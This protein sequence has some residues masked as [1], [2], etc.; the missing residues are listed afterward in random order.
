MGHVKTVP[1]VKRMYSKII[2]DKFS[3]DKRICGRRHERDP[4]IIVLEC[5]FD[6]NRE[7]LEQIKEDIEYEKGREVEWG[8]VP[9]GE[10]IEIHTSIK[11]LTEML[12]TLIDEP[13]VILP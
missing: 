7:E 13:I 2:Y 10:T 8:E 1:R 3:D 11:R 5:M 6:Y 4:D 9:I 12:S